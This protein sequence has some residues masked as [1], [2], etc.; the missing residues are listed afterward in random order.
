MAN[1]KKKIFYPEKE[2]E[3]PAYYNI[4]YDLLVNGGLATKYST[5]SNVLTLLAQHNTEIPIALQKSQADGQIAEG[6]KQAKDVRLANGRVEMFRELTRM[7]GL[8]IWEETDGE[9][10]G[11]R[12][13]KTPVDLNTVKGKISKT[14]ALA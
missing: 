7:T 11:I 8:S 4:I 9:N 3:I 10:M 6:S 14:T 5:P 2:T 12:K 1:A 13:E